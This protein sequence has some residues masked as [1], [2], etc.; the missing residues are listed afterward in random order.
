VSIRVPLAVAVAVLTGCPAPP[1]EGDPEAPAFN[2][3][4]RMAEWLSGTF[5][6][7]QQSIDEPQ[8]FPIQLTTCPVRAPELGDTVVYIEQAVMDSVDAPYRQRLYVIRSETAESGAPVART[9]VHTL[10][11]EAGAIGQCAG[12]RRTYTAAD[13]VLREGCD[14]VS[15][16]NEAEQAFDGGTVGTSCASSLQGARYATSEVRVEPDLLQSWDR[17]FDAGGAQVWGAT[18]GPYRFVRRD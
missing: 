14:V 3:A 15:E 1:A 11:D 8:Y 16:W 12:D 2:A 9:I 13:A 4:E 7:E 5:D 10:G 18:A 6:S 17:G